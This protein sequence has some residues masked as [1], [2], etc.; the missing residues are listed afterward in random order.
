MLTE[1]EQTEVHK[2]VDEFEAVRDSRGP[3]WMLA[4][5]R[6]NRLAE[7]TGELYEDVVRQYLAVWRADQTTEVPK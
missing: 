6:L 5:V 2:M 4:A 1:Q 7:T 3:G